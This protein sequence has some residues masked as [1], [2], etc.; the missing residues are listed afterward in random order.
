LV[1][2]GP[3][4]ARAVRHGRGRGRWHGRVIDM[5]FIEKPFRRGPLLPGIARQGPGAAKGERTD[6]WGN[7]LGVTL[8]PAWCKPERLSAL[9]IHPMILPSSNACRQ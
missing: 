4:L 5:V 3:W 8:D 6:A 9:H 7:R 1:P 2:V